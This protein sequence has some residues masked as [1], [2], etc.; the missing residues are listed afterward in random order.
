MGLKWIL[1]KKNI[2]ALQNQTSRCEFTLVY[3]E[4]KTCPVFY[5]DLKLGLFVAR[6]GKSMRSARVIFCLSS[7]CS[8]IFQVTDLVELLMIMIINSSATQSFFVI[9]TKCG[10]ASEWSQSWQIYTEF[11]C[12]KDVLIFKETTQNF[13]SLLHVFFINGKILCW[14][15]VGVI[16]KKVKPFYYHAAGH[17]CYS[18]LKYP[19]IIGLQPPHHL[20]PSCPV[21]TALHCL[22]HLKCCRKVI[23]LPVLCWNGIR[24]IFSAVLLKFSDAA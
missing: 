15:W 11:N 2:W 23:I 3:Q 22:A 9:K 12:V 17:N 20:I 6:K 14:D 8:N 5:A 16:K 21:K 4:H 19:T 7:P 24:A 1:E 10:T 18:S 13:F